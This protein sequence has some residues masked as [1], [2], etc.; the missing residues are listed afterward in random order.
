[1]ICPVEISNVMGSIIVFSTICNFVLRFYASTMLSNLAVI[2]L[3]CS[4]KSST[5]F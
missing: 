4:S 2:N 1:M 3:C 5:I